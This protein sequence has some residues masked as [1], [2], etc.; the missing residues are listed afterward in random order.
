M[1]MET[2]PQ[3]M[4]MNASQWRGPMRRMTRFE[5][6]SKRKYLPSAGH[7]ESVPREEDQKGNVVMIPLEIDIHSHASNP[8][9]TDIYTAISLNFARGGRIPID[10]SEGI[11]KTNPW[12]EMP[13]DLSHQSTLTI[14][15]MFCCRILNRNDILRSF[16]RHFS[17]FCCS[18]ENGAS[19]PQSLILYKR[20]R[21]HFR[22]ETRSAVR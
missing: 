15:R 4:M 22:S 10:K 13:V 7:G 21:S 8:S 2:A 14:K 16:L 5:G 9:H 11:E 6:S 20:E 12:Q 17:A 19:G 1:P 18:R 3:Q